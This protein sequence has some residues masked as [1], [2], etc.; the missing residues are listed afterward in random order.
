MSQVGDAWKILK[1][2]AD[3]AQ[4]ERYGKAGDG[5]IARM[6]DAAFWALGLATDP[7]S[8]ASDVVYGCAGQ[9]ENDDDEMALFTNERVAF[10]SGGTVTVFARQSLLSLEVLQSPKIYATGGRQEHDRPFRLRLT[11]QNG[12]SFVIPLAAFPTSSNSDSLASLLP[13][14]VG[15][16]SAGA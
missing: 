7:E 13:S 15:D 10:G 8:P 14:L 4:V 16:L 12:V 6:A 9:T 2:S 3:D 1:E 5:A 11:Y